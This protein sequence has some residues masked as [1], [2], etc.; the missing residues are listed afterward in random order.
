[1]T[2]PAQVEQAVT[3]YLALIDGAAPGLIEGFYLGGSLA[4]GCF[5]VGRSDIDFVATLARTASAR[6]LAA[7]RNVHRRTWAEG[8]WRAVASRSWPLV[9]NGVFLAEQADLARTPVTVTPIAAQVAGMFALG[10]RSDV[11][12]VTW[13]TL[14]HHGVTVRGPDLREVEVH[15]DDAELRRWTVANLDSYWRPWAWAISGGGPA[16]W[17]AW[18]RQAS[19]RRPIAWGVL[20]TARMHATIVTGRVISKDQAGE[21]ALN[22][23]EPRWHPIIREALTYWRRQPRPADASL[24]ALR[25][26]TAAFVHHVIDLAS[27]VSRSASVLPSDHLEPGSGG[28]AP[29]RLRRSRP[30]MRLPGSL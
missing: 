17:A 1:M 27:S 16:P 30:R 29:S 15:T 5:R 21:H 8:C 18:L 28:S 25:N 22:T 6:E 3:R 24:A 7:L 13:W 26:D 23:F 10:G 20:G 19:L 9:C 12:P 2:L 14:A 11:N 4:L